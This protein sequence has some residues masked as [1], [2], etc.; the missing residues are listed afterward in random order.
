MTCKQKVLGIK[1]ELQFSHLSEC[2]WDRY[3]VRDTQ[4][5]CIKVG[6]WVNHR[7]LNSYMTCQCQFK[8]LYHIMC[9][10]ACQ[11]QLVKCSLV[12]RILIS[13][14]AT[15]CTISACDAS[16]CIIL[17]IFWRIKN[18]VPNS[19]DDTTCYYC[20]KNKIKKYFWKSYEMHTYPLCI[21]CWIL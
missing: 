16:N 14:L 15:W 10:C 21:K 11:K 3:W 17:L 19:T 13:C 12:M 1:C 7:A 4:E 18:L 20:S 8:Y 6:Q 9:S 5:H 2:H